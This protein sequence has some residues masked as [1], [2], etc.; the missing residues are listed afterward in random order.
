MK[1]IAAALLFAVLLLGL[2]GNAFSQTDPADIPPIVYVHDGVLQVYDPVARASQVITAADSERSMPFYRAAWSPDGVWLAFSTPDSAVPRSSALTIDN[3][4]GT[5][6]TL[7]SAELAPPFA[8][9]WTLDDRLIYATY[10]GEYQEMTAILNVYAVAAATG[11]IPEL[12]GQFA[13]GEG[14]GGG[15][16]HP[17][18]SAY[19]YDTSLGGYREVFTLTPFGLVHDGQCVGAIVTLTDLASGEA[20]PLADGEL[21]KAAV[22][23]DGTRV[24]GIREGQLTIVNLENLSF[25]SFATAA[26]P[27]QVAWEASGS[28]LYSSYE[29]TGD[30]LEPYSA[31]EIEIVREV[32]GFLPERMPRRQVSLHRFSP[33]N[34]EDQLLYTADAFAVGRLYVRGN[35]LIFSQIDNADRWIEGMVNG[36]I[37]RDTAFDDTLD[38]VAVQVFALDFDNG[39]AQSLLDDGQQITVRP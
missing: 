13:V 21:V 12:L 16:S 39:E 1:H 6:V 19:Y 7:V 17:S 30:L 8:P 27:D 25:E 4:N 34:G 18:E 2:A 15:T 33:A 38:T 20:V 24:A 31:D 14:C 36:T 5:R 28:L 35:W 3:L 32:M 29:D 37:T 9:S 23:P 11:A 10:T 26:L 22:S